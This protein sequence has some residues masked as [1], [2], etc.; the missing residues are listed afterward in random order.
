VTEIRVGPDGSGS[1]R[2]M[3]DGVLSADKYHNASSAYAAAHKPQV[4][5]D[6]GL[7]TPA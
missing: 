5:N 2:Y 7:L 6:D 1:Y 3:I 4:V